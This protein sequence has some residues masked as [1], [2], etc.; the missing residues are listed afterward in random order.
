MRR[1]MEKS[2]ERPFIVIECFSNSQCHRLYREIQEKI[3][4]AA[5]KDFYIVAR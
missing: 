4:V 1:V 2:P 3:D 5:V